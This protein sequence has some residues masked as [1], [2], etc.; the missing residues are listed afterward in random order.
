V[1]A[2]KEL[3]AREFAPHGAL[4]SDQLAQLE[5][6][7]ELLGRWNTR[8]NLTRIR[9]LEDSVRLH[10]CESL[11]VGKTLPSGS[12]KIVDIGSGGGF[13][14]IPLAILRPECSVTLV[15]SHQ[16]K[17][18]FL[19]EASRLLKNVKVISERAEEV[20]EQFD[21]LVSRAVAP[22]DVLSLAIA[23]N[24]ALLVGEGEFEG[25]QLL[26]WGDRR[27]LAVVPR[28]TSPRAA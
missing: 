20:R 13:P 19:Q 27:F 4:S 25:A 15:E 22:N 10:Y 23:P 18:V 3:L 11:F 9:S 1:T 7:Y 16:R 21:W 6:H 14:G 26:P 28:G 24:R 2:F 5:A 17:A 12:L 8:L